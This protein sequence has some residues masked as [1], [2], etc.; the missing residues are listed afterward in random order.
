MYLCGDQMFQSNAGGLV[1]AQSFF[2][3]Y[4]FLNGNNF[5]EDQRRY[6]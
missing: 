6:I 4:Y 3:Y 1:E 5:I 2:F